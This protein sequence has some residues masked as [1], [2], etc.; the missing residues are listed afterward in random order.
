MPLVQHYLKDR[1]ASA[2]WAS[3]DTDVP[4]QSVEWGGETY[5][6][7]AVTT[8]GLSSGA[9]MIQ[10][11]INGHDMGMFRPFDAKMGSRLAERLCAQLR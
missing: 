5:D 3:L 4:H 8:K 2:V 10:V 9:D 1:L 6:V 7:H 11:F